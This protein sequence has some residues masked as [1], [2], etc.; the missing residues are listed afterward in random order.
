MQ[1]AFSEVDSRCGFFGLGRHRGGR[2]GFRRFLGG[3][4][5]AAFLARRQ[6]SLQARFFLARRQILLIQNFCG[7]AFF[8]RSNGFCCYRRCRFGRGCRSNYPALAYL[9]LYRAS[10]AGTVRLLDFGG[11]AADQRDLF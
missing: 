4:A 9:N 2:L 5:F 3:L 7:F 8:G 6:L 11:F 1:C 10:A